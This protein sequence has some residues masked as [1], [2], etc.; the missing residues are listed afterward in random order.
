MKN[1]L[2]VS[3]GLKHCFGD[4]LL[5]VQWQHVQVPQHPDTH[6]VLLQIVPVRRTEVVEFVK[7]EQKNIKNRMNK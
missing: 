7:E 2:V 5:K 1:V 4:K 6:T 3:P